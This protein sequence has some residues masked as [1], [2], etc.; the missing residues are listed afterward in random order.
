MGS[1]MRVD[2]LPVHIFYYYYFF[3]GGLKGGG[4]I[5]IKEPKVKSCACVSCQVYRHTLGA[6]WACGRWVVWRGVT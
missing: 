5:I 1:L 6:S 3:R 4:Q 2:A